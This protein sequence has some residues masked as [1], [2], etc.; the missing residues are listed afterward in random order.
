MGASVPAYW[1]SYGRGVAELR[2]PE[3]VVE[4]S[5]RIPLEGGD[6][7]RRVGVPCEGHCRDDE[8]SLAVDVG[9]QK[10][11]IAERQGLG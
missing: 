5:E 7:R 2:P 11:R 6:L 9:E 3:D 1:P 4:T 10:Q 8:T